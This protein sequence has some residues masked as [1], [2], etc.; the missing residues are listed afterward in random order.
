MHQ[1]R[2]WPCRRCGRS[3]AVVWAMVAKPGNGSQQRLALGRQLHA[4]RAGAHQLAADPEFEVADVAAD[5]RV[6]D[7]DILGGATHAA[8]PPG[9]LEGPQHEQRRQRVG[10][11]AAL[12]SGSVV[13]HGPG[14]VVHLM[15]HSIVNH[16]LF[17]PAA[18]ALFLG[19]ITGESN[20]HQRRLARPPHRRH[21]ARRRQR[22]S[23]LSPSAPRTPRLWD[24][25]G[26]RYVDF[27]GGIAV[28]NTGHRH[29]QGD[30]GG[31]GPARRLHPHRLP[32][33]CPTSPTS[34]SPSGSTPWRP[35]A[36]AAKTDPLLHRRRGGRERRQDRPRRHRP[37]PASSPS[38]AA[39][40]AAPLLTMALTGKVVPYKKGFGPLPG[41][42]L[43]RAIPP[44]RGT[45]STVADSLRGAR[46]PLPR[47]RRPVSG[48]PRSSSS[49]CRARAAS[50]W[51]RPSCC[52]RCA[53]SATSTA[54]C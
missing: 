24:V 2:S 40:T 6:A 52:G 8:S 23:G 5:H 7:A 18:C 31:R 36:G 37:A 3:S 38:P 43:P 46:L 21:S 30:R 15:H 12:L 39:S 14:C 44:A 28:L 19:R 17:E 16:L 35:F 45:A 33:R 25:E 29:P 34:R 51:P 50:T 11:L 53:R 26:R 22:H 54:S 13:V 1:M 48:S 20:D 32:G 10:G 41:G 4:A 47:R 9:R 27:A 42:R 49:R